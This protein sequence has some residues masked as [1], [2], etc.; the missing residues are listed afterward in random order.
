MGS[1]IP[2]R[3]FDERPLVGVADGV[4][5]LIAKVERMGINRHWLA[6]CLLGV[7]VSTQTACGNEQRFAFHGLSYDQAVDMPQVDMLDCLYGDGLGAHTQKEVDAGQARRGECGNMAGDMPIGDFLYV[8]WR[9]KR[10]QKVYEDRVDL[11]SRLPSPNEMHK[12]TVAFLIDENQLYVYLVPDS[13]WDT[14]RNHLPEGKPANGPDLFKHLDVKTLYPD[15]A[16]PQVRGG[17]PSARAEREAAEK[18][19]P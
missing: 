16:P 2:R 13:D 12:K 17:R 6:A 5:W 11:K 9:D 18:V 15:N 3:G 4:A 14:K 1:V 19:K 10:S 8:K 7:V